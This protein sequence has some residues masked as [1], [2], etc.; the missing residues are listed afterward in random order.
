MT[1]FVWPYVH[2]PLTV[3]SIVAMLAVLVTPGRTR[4]DVTL[5]LAG[6]GLGLFLE[7]WGTSR[8]CWNYYTGEIPPL[9][10]I[11]AHGFASVAFQ[12]IAERLER[13]VRGGAVP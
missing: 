2:E 12:R 5:M 1:A 11:F 9:A 3:L 4:Q 8:H 10:A 7:Y 6:S 13:L